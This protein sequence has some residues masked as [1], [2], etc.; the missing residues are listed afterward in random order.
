MF[1]WLLLV[2]WTGYWIVFIRSSLLVS[3]S[4]RV[5]GGIFGGI[6]FACAVGFLYTAA[7]IFWSIAKRAGVQ[8]W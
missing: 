5:R 2:P 8:F 7:A 4:Q 3:R 1:L 6:A